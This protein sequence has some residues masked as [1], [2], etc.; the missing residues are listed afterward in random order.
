MHDMA[1]ALVEQGLYAKEAQAMVKTWQD[2][3]F[4][5]EGTRVLYL[6]PRAWTDRTL[7]LRVAPQPDDVVRVMVGRA[8]I[9]TPT[10]ERKL[11]EQ[12]LTFSRG[13]AQSKARAVAGALGLGRFLNAAMW[14]VG[15]DPID[16]VQSRATWELNEA[17]NAR[18]ESRSARN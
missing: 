4:E 5:E 6:L 1:A 13:D 3:W 18:E 2:Q 10:M 11:R 12:I 17:L 7:Q 15:R 9:I 14:K 8:E 16:D